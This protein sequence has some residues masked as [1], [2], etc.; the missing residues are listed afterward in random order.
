MSP[1]IGRAVWMLAVEIPTAVS[2]S[3]ARACRLPRQARPVFVKRPEPFCPGD[4][5][6]TMVVDVLIF[7]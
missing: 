6:V 4:G 2:I 3:A 1:E 5:S 7:G